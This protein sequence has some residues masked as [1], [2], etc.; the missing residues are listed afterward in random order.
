[1]RNPKRESM[2]RKSEEAAQ[3]ISDLMKAGFSDE[4]IG[5][6]LGYTRKTVLNYRHRF[7]FRR[8]GIYTKSERQQMVEMYK[9][10]IRVTD[11]AKKIGCHHNTVTYWVKRGQTNENNV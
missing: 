11:I 2:Y 10:G 5:R 1:M 8:K 3:L 6:E 4:E 7:G 9:D